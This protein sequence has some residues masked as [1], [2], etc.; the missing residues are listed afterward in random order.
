MGAEAIGEEIEPTVLV[1]EP[2]SSEADIPILEVP[3]TEPVPVAEE[4]PSQESMGPEYTLEE[5]P[6]GRV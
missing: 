5:S 3:S 2:V 4:P 1:S 6:L